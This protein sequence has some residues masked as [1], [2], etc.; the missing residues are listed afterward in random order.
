[1]DDERSI[2]HDPWTWV[3]LACAIAFLVL[4]VVVVHRGGLPFDDPVAAAIQS[5]PLPVGFWQAC[6][7]AGGPLL[8][9]VGAALVL[10]CL[11]SRHIRLAFIVAIVLI[12]A[13]LF[14]EVV[15]GLVERPRP[16]GEALAP[17]L[18]YSFPSGHTLNSTVTYGLLAVVAWR[19]HL[20]VS[21]RRIAVIAGVA[22]P[23]LVGLSRVALGV[24]F[25]SDVLA[26]WL[27]GVAFV[28]LGACLIRATGAMARA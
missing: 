8:V 9:L 2:R 24:H 15:K 19:S 20:P 25:P 13:A 10:A 18:G 4:A 21:V 26:G 11:V 1:M 14:T 23:C 12:A 16:P 3:G 7:F 22:I 5:L 27:A 6:T 28:A 17:W